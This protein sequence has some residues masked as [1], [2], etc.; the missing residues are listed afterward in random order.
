MSNDFSD[1]VRFDKILKGKICRLNKGF[2][3]IEGED[4]RDYF[5]HWSALDKFSKQFRNLQDGDKVEFQPGRTSQGP[6]AFQVTT[7]DEAV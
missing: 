1:E 6:R 4:G 3:F 5:F 7:L 2:G